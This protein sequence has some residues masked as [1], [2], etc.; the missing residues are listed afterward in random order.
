MP[1]G[2]KA[3]DINISRSKLNSIEDQTTIL[4]QQR[5]ASLVITDGHPFDPIFSPAKKN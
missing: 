2:I 5:F 4:P 1:S 3:M